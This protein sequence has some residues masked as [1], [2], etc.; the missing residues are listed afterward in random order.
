MKKRYYITTPIYYVN[1][2]PHIGH[3]YTTVAA[4]VL[5]RWAKLRNKDTFFLTGTDEHGS[6]ILE[7][8]KEKNKQPKEYCDEIV[9]YFKNTWKQMD[10]SYD[11]FIRTTD[12]KHQAAVEKFI[13][14]LHEKNE[15]YKS[16]YDGLYCMGCEKF[17]TQ[18]D[19]VEG[20][21]PDHKTVPSVHS[22][23]NY[24]FRLSKYREKLIEIISDN[25][26]P[27]HFDILPEERRNEILGKLKIGLEDISISRANLPWAIPI[28]FDKSQTIYVWIDALINYISALGYGEA[29]QEEFNEL[30]PAD[31]HLLAKDILWFHTVI[32]PAMLLANGLPLPKKVF[33][34]GFFTVS[35]QKMS[36][37]IGNVIKPGELI[38][39]FGADASRFLLLNS[40]PFGADGDMNLAAFKGKYNAHLANN[41]GNLISR[42]TNMAVKYFSGKFA[43]Q[44]TRTNEFMEEIK[45]SLQKTEKE[46]EDIKLDGILETILSLSSFTNQYIDKQAPWNLAKTDMKQLELVLYNSLMA[47]KYIAVLI[48]PFMPETSRKIWK[49]LDEQ[50]DIKNVTAK[51]PAIIPLTGREIAKSQILFPK[52]I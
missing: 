21:C 4:D 17:L 1:D 43:L 12:A 14:H 11:R 22:E 49:T 5:S 44:T 28:P 27:Q 24:F 29:G 23:E 31:L 26:H 32:W 9:E 36:K 19:L 52:I 2:L 15:I 20:C 3:T 39:A 51:I 7:A 8:A 35:G 6:K 38:Q 34:H 41:I 40:F 16:K 33:A 42:V 45:K 47:I 13:T 37:T 10:I 25:N 50:D 48:N 18:T 30:W 46:I